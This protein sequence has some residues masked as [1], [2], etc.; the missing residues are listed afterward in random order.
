MDSFVGSAYGSP[1]FVVYFSEACAN[2]VT[3]I[4]SIIIYKLCYILYR[5]IL[6]LV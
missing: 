6:D 4:L 2:I 3:G 5:S 1:P